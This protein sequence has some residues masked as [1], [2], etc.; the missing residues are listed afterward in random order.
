MYT[1]VLCLGRVLARHPL[2]FSYDTF[3]RRNS[4]LGRV[5]EEERY[6]REG[7]REG[8]GWKELEREKEKESM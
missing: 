8:D 7:M 6:G 2:Q 5:W 3:T 1:C 4:K